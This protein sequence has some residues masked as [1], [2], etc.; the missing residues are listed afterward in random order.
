MASMLGFTNGELDDVQPLY[1][2]DG[3]KVVA[4][5]YSHVHVQTLAYF[6]AL[7]ARNERSARMLR[8]TELMIMRNQ[9]DYTAWQV[10]WEC[11]LALGEEADLAYEFDFTHGIMRDNA[12]N[13]QLWNHR[14]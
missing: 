10:R 11:I 5:Q 4:I 3:G 13:Y 1:V 7:I 6:R 12:K 9:A 2:D 14:R 8:M